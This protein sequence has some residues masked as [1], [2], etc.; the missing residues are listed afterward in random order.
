MGKGLKKVDPVFKCHEKFYSVA[1]DADILLLEN[2]PEYPIEDMVRDELGAEWTA[3][4]A[5]VD[6]RH[7]GLGCAR[8]RIYGIAWRH[9]LFRWNS[10]Y[11]LESILDAL[12]ARPRMTANDYYFLDCPPSRLTD[13]EDL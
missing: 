3:V 7:F 12:K 11:P 10:Q 5:K 4:S 13:S 1:E 6:P 2:V 8:P 9:A